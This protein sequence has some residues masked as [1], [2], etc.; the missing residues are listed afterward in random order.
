MRTI[1]DRA[2]NGV[3]LAHAALGGDATSLAPEDYETGLVDALT[4]LMHMAR[5]YEIDFDAKLA[6]A[7]HHH[8]VESTY[9]WDAVPAA[10]GREE[11]RST[12]ATMTI[13]TFTVRT[14]ANI[15]V[16]GD[17]ADLL[18]GVLSALE[19]DPRAI[20]PVCGYDYD[21]QEIDAIFQVQDDASVGLDR[22]LAASAAAQIFDRA[23]IEGAGVAKKTFDL[24]I[25]EGDDPDL[26]P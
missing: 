2:L 11:E 25:V 21:R 13:D 19:L 18:D 15:P 6:E 12:M 14:A 1:L 3:D 7:R 17:A 20:A 16:D 4:N 10:Y 22:D 9:P 8:H 26:L 5:R 24:A 23:L